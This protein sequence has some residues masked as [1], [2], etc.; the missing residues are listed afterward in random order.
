MIRDKIRY[1]MN[2]TRSTKSEECEGDDKLSKPD[3]RIISRVVSWQGVSI[4]GV[5]HFL[6]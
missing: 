5:I 3:S 2:G 4:S 6:E 1:E